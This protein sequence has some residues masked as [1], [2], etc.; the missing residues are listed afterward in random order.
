MSGLAEESPLRGDQPRPPRSATAVVEE[1]PPPPE[2]RQK[3]N[4]G[5]GAPRHPRERTRSGQARAIQPPQGEARAAAKRA[6]RA[7]LTNPDEIDNKHERLIRPDHPAG[8]ALPVA[9]VRRDRDLAPAADLHPGHALVPAGDHL[10]LAQ[11]ELE[12]AAAVPGRVELAARA[13]RHADVV[14]LDDLAG[15]G[16]VAVAD[17]EVLDLELVRRRL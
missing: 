3:P 7:P 5:G 13:P 1:R 6:S 14:D 15:D 12:G 2:R 8:S 9:Q 16:F 10:A 11:A 4:R 17:R